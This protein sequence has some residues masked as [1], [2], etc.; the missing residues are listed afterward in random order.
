MSRYVKFATAI[1]WRADHF[2]R[3]SPPFRA[4]LCDVCAIYVYPEE[5]VYGLPFGLL[6]RAH[7]GCLFGPA[8]E[9][10]SSCRLVA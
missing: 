5:S 8:C 3:H 7:S 4:L 9:I 1:G 6:S 10:D 2:H